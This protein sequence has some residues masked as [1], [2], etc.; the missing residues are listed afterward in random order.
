MCRMDGWREMPNSAKNVWFSQT[1]V[2]GDRD[3]AS[4]PP[5][6]MAVEADPTRLGSQASKKIFNLLFEQARLRSIKEGDDFKAP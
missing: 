6:W 5:F 4:G 2:S 1:A 3:L